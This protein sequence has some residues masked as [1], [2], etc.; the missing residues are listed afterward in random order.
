M[1]IASTV[2]CGC[3]VNS[4][5]LSRGDAADPIISAGGFTKSYVRSGPFTL[6]TC[7]RIASPGAPVRIYI[8]GDGNAWKSRAY[9]SEDP[10][11]SNPVA[12]YC[13]ARDPS[14]NVAYIARPGQYRRSGDERCEPT[15]WSMRR[16]SPEVIDA[17][18]GVIDTLKQEA[19]AS[20]VELVG[21]SGGAAIAVLVAAQ[22]HDVTAL[23]TVA[24]NLDWERFCEYH[25]IS[26]LTGSRNPVD[27]AR[28]IAYIPQHHF[29]GKNDA[30]EPSFIA[31]RFIRASGSPDT[32]E[33]SIIDRTT[34]SKG[35]RKVWP[36]LLRRYPSVEGAILQGATL[37]DGTI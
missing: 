23:R 21:F 4:L 16:F 2:L 3:A 30:V 19:R 35:W 36:E 18:S 34:H 27:V 33:I 12:L 37:R 8:E 32:V 28:E 7:S 13:A 24:G 29:F 1:I 31:D 6:M 10:T 22:R 20:S 26:P 9:L 5:F 11:P 25:N 14:S 17:V 15:Y